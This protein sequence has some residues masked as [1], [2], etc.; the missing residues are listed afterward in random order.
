MVIACGV[1]GN[2]RVDRR[3]S[4]FYIPSTNQS[5]YQ[6]PQRGV[7]MARKNA[8]RT[9]VQLTCESGA[10]T[11]HTEKNRR[12]TPDRITLRKYCPV[13]RSHEEFRESRR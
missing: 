9:L 8:V 4:A 12:N 5:R 13:C 3:R 2:I 7:E 1:R 6:Y 11:Y 10:Y